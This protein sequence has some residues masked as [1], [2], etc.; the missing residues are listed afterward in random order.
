[1]PRVRAVPAWHARSTF[2][3]QTENW[4]PETTTPPQAYLNSGSGLTVSFFVATSLPSTAS[5]IL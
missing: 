3:L 4:Q 1:M 5:V 2:G